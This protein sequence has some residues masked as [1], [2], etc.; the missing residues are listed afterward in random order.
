MLGHPYI[1]F[2]LDAGPKEQLRLD[3][4]S[5]DCFLLVEQLLA[6]VHSRTID[7]FPRQVMLLRYAKAKPNYCLIR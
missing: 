3:L 4:T 5:F 7:D 6:L 1:A 2:S